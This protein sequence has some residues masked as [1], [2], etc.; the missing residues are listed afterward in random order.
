MSPYLVVICGPDGL[1]AA[2]LARARS[3]LASFTKNDAD[4]M[5]SGNDGCL[6]G[7]KVRTDKRARA[8][9]D[10]IGAMFDFSITGYVGALKIGD[11]WAVDGNAVGFRHMQD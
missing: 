11:D 8:L 4:V 5:F 1:P 2:R 7:I 6:L 3:A 9:V 10:R